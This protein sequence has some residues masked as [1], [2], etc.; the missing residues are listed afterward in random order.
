MHK[1][2]TD[3][4]I[5]IVG[6]GPVGLFLANECARRGL[7]YRIVEKRESQSIHSKALAIFPRTLEIFDMAGVAEPFIK[8]AN[9]VTSAAIIV[10]DHR[11]AHLPFTPKE[12]PYPFIAMV[13]QDVTEQLLAGSLTQRGGVI[14]Y[15]TTFIAATQHEDHVSVTLEQTGQSQTLTASYVVG[16]DG[17]HSAVRHCLNLP[18]DGAQYKQSFMLADVESNEAL[19]VDEF[20]LCPSADGPLAIFPM[21]PTR[22][23]IVAM[24]GKTEGDAPGLDLVRKLLRERAPAE[25]EAKSMH[26]SS[27]FHIHHRNTP[28]LRQQR[29]FIAGDAAHIH[30]PFGGQGMN[31]GLHDVW[32]LVWK[33]DLALRGQAGDILL[34]SYSTE[35]LPV[36]KSVIQLTDFLTRAMG[37][38]NRFAEALRDTV[39]P[40]VSRLTPVQHALVQ[41]LSELGIAYDGSPIVEGAGERYFEDSLRGGQGIRSKFILLAGSDATADTQNAVQQLVAAFIDRLELRANQQPGFVLLRPDGYVAYTSAHS[42]GKTLATIQTLMEQQTQ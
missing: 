36:I 2:M 22:R 32:N 27:Y 39:I 34:D 29:I 16:C 8:A 15:A 19:P 38:P 10:R 14:D 20:Q 13:P 28:T 31:T 35:R 23:R 37:T 41:K 17:A 7:R 21:A 18:F 1:S 24:I 5:L 4:D 40:L 3:T 26:W 9:R 30:S 33:L 11:I 25:F 42:S 6:A 12:S